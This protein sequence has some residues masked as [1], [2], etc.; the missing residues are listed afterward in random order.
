MLP[1]GQTVEALLPPQ[2]FERLKKLFSS[3]GLP[4]AP[5]SRLKVWA[6]AVQVGLLDYIEELSSKQPLDMALYL[7]AQAAGK[8]VGGIETVDEQLDI[9]DGLS[10][11]EQARMLAQTLDL[12]DR[13]A[14]S[15]RDLVEELVQAYLAGDERRLLVL[16]EETYDADHPVDRKVMHKLLHER[17]G[18]M[19]DRIEARLSAAPAQTQF[20]AIGAGHL[21]G[22]DG[23]VARLLAKGIKIR[24]VHR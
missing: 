2:L 14:G 4:L 10:A 13:L 9:F 11:E 20:F 16:M 24:R 22:P 17:N 8:Q 19:A 7:R 6:L 12:Y 21:G 1:E 23:V 3:R 15:G 5:L 18:T